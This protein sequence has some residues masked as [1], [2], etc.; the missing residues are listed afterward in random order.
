MNSEIAR[1][2]MVEQQIRVWDVSDEAVLATMRSIARE[3]FVPA[4][5]EHLAY[6]DTEIP[7]GHGQAML[8]PN[9][10]GRV[11]QALQLNDQQSV[12]EIGTG[13]GYLTACLAALAG[14][15][16]SIDCFQ[17][18]VAQAGNKLADAGIDNVL[19]ECMDAIERLPVGQFDAIAVS[20]AIPQPDRRL[21]ESLKPG[22]RMFVFIGESP[23][24]SAQLVTTGEGVA[25]QATSLFETDVAAL[26]NTTPTPEFS[27]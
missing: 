6:A 3:Y 11:L 18:F 17:D 19:V 4:G 10:D 27:F 23:L 14:S 25:W 1:Q 16:T 7:L 22:G 5:F 12:L 15:V 24:V 20:G 9:I 13:S 21:L 2:H 26:Q 8:K